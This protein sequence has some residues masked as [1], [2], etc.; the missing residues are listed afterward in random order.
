MSKSKSP[1]ASPGKPLPHCKAIRKG[2]LARLNVPGSDATTR[3]R[4]PPV[5]RQ[6]LFFLASGLRGIIQF[7]A[8]AAPR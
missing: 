6:K 3:V 5:P 2:I 8:V 1:D 7:V 4:L